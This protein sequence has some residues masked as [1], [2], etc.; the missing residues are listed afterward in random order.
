ME[1][2]GLLG[3][4]L[5][6]SLSPR[7]HKIIFESIEV[8]G[9]YKLF[10]VQKSDLNEFIDGVKVLNIKGASVTIPYKEEIIQYLDVVS[11]EAQ[12]IGSVN[13]ISLIDNKLYGYNTDYYGFGYMLD[14]HKV[15]LDQQVVVILGNGGATKSVMHY[16]LDNGVKKVYI[17]SRNPNKE[18]RDGLRDERAEIIGYDE[19]N[20][21]KGDMLVNATPVGM[22]PHEDESPVEDYIIENF[23]T[24]VD[25]IYNPA[26]TQLLC[27]GKELGKKTVGGLY[28]LI[29][30]G[31][32]AQ[33]I[34][35]NRSID[36]SVIKDIYEILNREF[37]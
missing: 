21:I 9:A 8:D 30:Q 31:V 17:A 28:M 29:G 18:R 35:Q 36:E 33:E 13:T 10:E 24:I 23:D 5:G 4:K 12:R 3:E 26:M 37:S 19:L 32:K 1:F 11:P 15:K 2:Y 34:W 20:D 25:I 22:F 6:H 16:L 27:K 14:V 7:I